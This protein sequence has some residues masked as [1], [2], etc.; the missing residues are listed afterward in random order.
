MIKISPRAIILLERTFHVRRLCIPPA[1]ATP[2]CFVL[3][4]GY[5]LAC[6]LAAPAL[7]VSKTYSVGSIIGWLRLCLH[8][9][10]S[11]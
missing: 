9:P 3:F 7:A 8:N 6:L 1:D 5:L 10:I 11:T 2:A 4:A